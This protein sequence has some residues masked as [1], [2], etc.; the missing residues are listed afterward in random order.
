MIALAHNIR[1]ICTLLF[2]AVDLYQVENT[3]LQW[4][5]YSSYVLNCYG[6]PFL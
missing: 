2:A 1:D 4:R 3:Q 5:A 6:Q